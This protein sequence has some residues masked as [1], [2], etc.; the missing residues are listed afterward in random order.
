MTWTII[1]YRGQHPQDYEGEP[2]REPM[3]GPTSYDTLAEARRMAEI[4]RRE[5]GRCD[6]LDEETGE[7][8]T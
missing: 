4:D 2:Q 6:I 5:G 3:L 8:V 7:I 1:Y